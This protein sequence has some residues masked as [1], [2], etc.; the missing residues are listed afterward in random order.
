MIAVFR[1]A[2]RSGR[3]RIVCGA[4]DD[5]LGCVFKK[6]HNLFTKPMHLSHVFLEFTP[7][8]TSTTAYQAYKCRA[9]YWIVG[10]STLLL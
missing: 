6:T 9:Y 3:D 5:F 1:S 8:V 2:E 10:S 4:N 7:I